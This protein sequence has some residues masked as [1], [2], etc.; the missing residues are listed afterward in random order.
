MSHGA[1]ASTSDLRLYSAPVMTVAL[2]LLIPAWREEGGDSQSG[3]QV[4][5]VLSEC[6]FIHADLY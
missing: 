4:I 5:S 6:G 2:G 3:A 1:A